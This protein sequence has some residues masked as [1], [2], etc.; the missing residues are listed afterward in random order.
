MKRSDFV[1]LDPPYP[2]LSATA[3]FQHYTT[4]RFPS[5]EQTR[6]SKY[7]KALSDKGVF[8]MLSNADLPVIRTLYKGW[9]IEE[10]TTTRYV[11]G[12][13]KKNKVSE[14]VIKNY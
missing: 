8:V 2:P 7:A 9:N 4:E 5:K 13:V 11:G 14:L 12:G 3:S 1:Y 10:L 6:L